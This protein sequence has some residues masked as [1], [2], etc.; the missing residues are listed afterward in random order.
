MNRRSFI[1][2]G[3]IITGGLHFR[4]LFSFNCNPVSGKSLYSSFQNPENI[5][6][7]FIRWW[8]DGDK[9]E[10]PELA[11]ELRLLKEADIGG[12]EINPIKFPAKTND[13]GKH[14]V[15]WLSDE[16]IELLQ[17]TFEQAKSLEMVCDLMVG[18][19][20]PFGAEWLEGDE[21]SQVVVIGTK[22]LEGPLDYKV[23]LTELLKDADPPIYSPF[24]ERKTEMLSVKLLPSTVNSIDDAKDLSDQIP[25]GQIKCK[26]PSGDF[27]LYALIK[28]ESFMRVIQGAPGADGPVLN[29][30]NQ[31]A[32][33]KYLAHMSSTIQEKIGPLSGKIRSLFADSLELEGSNWC[34]DMEEEFQKR[35]GY[36]LKPWLPYVLYK[37]AAMGNTWVFEYGVEYGQDFK[38]KIQRVRYDF[39]LTKAELLRERFFNSYIDWCKENNV[40]SRVQAYGRGYFPVEGSFGADIFECE[41]W[42]RPGL[43]I[44]MNESDYSRG[45]AYT[46][47]NKYVT[48][49]AHLKGKQHISCEELTNIHMVF[50]ESLELMKIASDQSIIS[51]ATH[52]ILHGF[53]YSPPDALFPGWVIYGSFINERAPWWKYFSYFIEYK[54]R[55]SA[56]LQQTTMFANIAV[57]PDTADLWSLY[58]A[59]NDPFPSVMWPP[60]QTFVW[61]A[62]HQ[63]GNGCD[64]V[65]EKI[66]QDSAIKNGYLGF[67]PRTYHAIFLTQVER[68]QPATAKKL[69]EFIVSGGRVLCIEVYPEKSC[70]FYNHEQNDKEV[71]EWVKKMKEYP[72]RFLLLKKPNSSFTQWFSSIQ[73]ECKLTP[74]VTIDTPNPFISQIRCQGSDVEMLVFTNSNMSESYEIKISPSADITRGRHPWIWDPESGQRYQL[75]HNNGSF[76]LDMGSAELKLL[77]FDKEKKGAPFPPAIVENDHELELKKPWSLIG[78]HVNGTSLSD[79]LISLKDLKEIPNWVNFCGHI[80]YHTNFDLDDVNN[81]E[82]LNL[83]KVYGVSDLFLNGISA[84]VKWYGRRIYPIRKYLKKGN[85]SIEVKITTIMGNYMKS[86]TENPIAQFWTNEGRTIQ[87]LQSMGLIGPVV[88]Y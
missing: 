86:L 42:I 53:N 79:E 12:I 35:R 56:V 23:S 68:L 33:K 85:N 65:S 18:S 31:A 76:T 67:G 28:I 32:V 84:G 39:E 37:I 38:E 48:S 63:N 82:W 34:Q 4:K 80:S 25:S 26:V 2:Q 62:I 71:Q 6:R 61:E 16:W 58:G 75:P 47:V 73:E 36:E 70:G 44:E 20:W 72:D 41:T 15:L 40:Q 3:T 59:Q 74:Y 45:R 19:G 64:Y 10:K 11:R 78:E 7:P 83:G 14:S 49:A 69:F 60:W 51:G 55:L 27:V 24:K 43:G 50:N 29:H 30:Y 88:L 52:S 46:M 57:L 81:F 13:L 77:V 8:W 54:T 1:T 66:I 5:Y 9:I 17:F 21:C 22:K 87:P